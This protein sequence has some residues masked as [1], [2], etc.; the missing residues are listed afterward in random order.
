MHV[1]ISVPKYAMLLV[2]FLQESEQNQAAASQGSLTER[3]GCLSPPMSPFGGDQLQA[4]AERTAVTD[5]RFSSLQRLSGTASTSDTGTQQ[6]SCSF[7]HT[8]LHSL[9]C[10]LTHS[11]IHSFV[12]SCVCSFFCSLLS[13]MHPIVGSVSSLWIRRIQSCV[14][15]CMNSWVPRQD[16][17]LAHPCM[18]CLAI[19]C[20]YKQQHRGL[21]Q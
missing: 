7:V 6:V 2:Y 18:L 10:S 1:T 12:F 14:A 15:P 16:R 8:L 21:L 4:A 3:T 5:A 11:F 9:V 13:F 19:L 17:L 20:G